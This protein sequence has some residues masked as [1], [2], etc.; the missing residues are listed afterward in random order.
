MRVSEPLAVICTSELGWKTVRARWAKALPLEF[1]DARF[2]NLELFS[3]SPKAFG[4]RGLRE[5]LNTRAAAKAAESAG[6]KKLLIATNTDAVLLAPSKAA[7]YFI[8]MDATH[9]QARWIYSHKPPTLKIKSRVNKVRELAK[10]GATFL[11]MSRLAAHGAAEEYRAK[12]DK[13]F[14]VPPP[15]DTDLFAP[16]PA[17]KH[18]GLRVIFI[19]GD[20][21]RKGGD[22]L[23]ELANDPDLKECEWHFV[24]KEDPA[25]H[26]AQRNTHFYNALQ[27]ESPQLVSL[28]QS[29]DLLGLPTRADAHSIA[30]LECLAC[31]KPVIIRNIGATSEAVEDGVSGFVIDKSNP[32]EVKAAMTRYLNQPGLLD[33]QGNAGREQVLNSNSLPVHARKIREAV[34]G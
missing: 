8:Y 12:L 31:A 9:F 29:C 11:C 32:A 5:M 7:S 27:P 34:S 24:T 22:V 23:L 16:A 3:K 19:G 26:N 30:A 15:V 4:S 20:F 10:S 21:Q 14:V 1:E 28:I 6:Y 18:P 25:T 33:I 13:I 2:F 17:A